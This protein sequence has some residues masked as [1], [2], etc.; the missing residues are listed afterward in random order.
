MNIKN[1]VYNAL[2]NSVDNGYNPQYTDSDELAFDL[3]QYDSELELITEEEIIMYVDKWR[4]DFYKEN[5]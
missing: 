4:E 3:I 5:K 2:N 1:V